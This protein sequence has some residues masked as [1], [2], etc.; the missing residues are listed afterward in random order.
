MVSLRRSVTLLFM[1]VLVCGGMLAQNV[2]V[3][4]Y[5]VPVSTA[6]TLRGTGSWAWKQSG[7]VPSSN[8]FNASLNFKTFYTS[9]PFAWLVDANGTTGKVLNNDWTYTTNA[10]GEVRK[11]VWENRDWFGSSRL[12]FGFAKNDSQPQIDLTVG[13]GYGRR[14]NATALA[15]AVRI[16]G[17]LMK[18]NLVKGHMPK[19]TM[20]KIGN[21]IE[22][23]SEY[24]DLYGTTYEVQWFSDIEKEVKASGELTGENV[25]AIGFL[26]M[27]QVLFGINEVVNPRFYGWDLSAGIK[28][29]LLNRYDL[30]A[31]KPRLNLAANYA[32]PLGWE[33]QVTGRLQADTPVDSNFFKRVILTA[34]A[35]YVYELSNRINFQADYSLGYDKI[36]SVDAVYSHALN[37][38]FLFYIEN[39]INYQ[40]RA[41][42]TKFGKLDPDKSINMGLVYNLFQ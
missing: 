35:D 23:E 1:I 36:P 15:K 32:Y 16:E 30:D 14:I 5:Q 11:Y 29:E 27:R 41:T 19:E 42:L 9:L 8:D 17:H 26:R 25:G 13:A 37:A 4:D 20:I 28:F 7:D 39:N 2:S 31:Q 3:T 38:G 21:I 6:R 33:M 10:A 34:G 22:R 18:E 12:D 40:V 24:R